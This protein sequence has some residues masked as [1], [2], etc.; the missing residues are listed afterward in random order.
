[1][2]EVIL[3]QAGIDYDAALARFVGKQAI[4]EKYLLK[5]LEDTHAQD[6]LA[7]YEQEDYEELFEQTHALKGVAGTLGMM[8]LY[9][10]AA[11]IVH[12]L[13]CDNREELSGKMAQM[14]AEQKR[15]CEIIA[16]A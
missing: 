2:D 8:G 5:F 12:D 4:Y 13:R 9:D 11:E 10:A 15:I 3:R 6:A 16:H 14:M 1:M 7:A